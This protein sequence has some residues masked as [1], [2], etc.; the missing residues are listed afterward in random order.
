MAYV[1]PNST[2]M[3]YKG[4]QL[5]N[6]YQNAFY[7]ENVDDREDTFSGGA[8]SYPVVATID[9]A[10]YQIAKD[11]GKIRIECNN[12]Y[13][14]GKTLYEVN[15]LRF[16]N[17]RY[18]NKWF[19]A[20]VTEVEYLNDKVCELTYEL[21]VLTTFYFD[22][23][24]E[25]CYIERQHS[26]RDRFEDCLVPENLET[27]EYIFNADEPLAP[28]MV[29]A[30]IYQRGWSIV[31]IADDT[32]EPNSTPAGGNV[33][34]KRYDGLPS[35][36]RVYTMEY[37]N[38][39]SSTNTWT[40]ATDAQLQAFYNS[41]IDPFVSQA[42]KKDALLGL[43]L[44]P[45]VLIPSV[46]SQGEPIQDVKPWVTVPESL[47]G[48]K[49]FNKKMHTFPYQF[50]YVCDTSGNA[51]TYKFE[52]SEQPVYEDECVMFGLIGNINAAP[53]EMLI[54]LY[55][56]GSRENIDEAM[57]FSN[58][59][60]LSLVTSGFKEW[61]SANGEM[62]SLNALK[63]EIGGITSAVGGL[64]SIGAGSALTAGL[65][66]VGLLGGAASV[67]MAIATKNAKM[68]QQEIQ[69]NNRVTAGNCS[70]LTARGVDNFM[71][72]VKEVTSPM[73]RSIDDYFSMFGYAYQRLGTPPR[74]NRRYWTYV[75]T[76]G[77]NAVA[78]MDNN[79]HHGVPQMYL[80]KICSIFDNGVTHWVTSEMYNI[81]NYTQA[82]GTGG[83]GRRVNDPLG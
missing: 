60:Q 76:I 27:G 45:T 51:G 66:V 63:G 67:G 82:Y 13:L 21:D 19:Y 1:T 6:T 14:N 12:M 42:A 69:P 41:Y 23:R 28:A 72:G 3:L 59:P 4:V 61:L 18:E 29:Y 40:Y 36:M 57:G 22:Y 54:P 8:I 80:K 58:I 37:S 25:D 62:T 56:K 5:D 49:P 79:Q 24:L 53:V 2:I 34:L 30:G 15:Y 39:D 46:G 75:K 78:I 55:Y 9:N 38:Y 44:Y 64:V 11:T 73:A 47:D 32:F 20:F 50:V 74:H 7:F 65:G 48:Y 33:Y 16:K 68:K 43:Y 77:C 26:Y 10:M 83:V 35:S 17:T 52:F 81:G 31:L 71:I 70:P